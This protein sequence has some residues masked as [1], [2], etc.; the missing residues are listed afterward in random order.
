MTQTLAGSAYTGLV[1]GASGPDPTRGSVNKIESTR[2]YGKVEVD[3]LAVPATGYNSF[4]TK[5]NG[6][7]GAGG[8]AADFVRPSGAGDESSADS[9]ANATRAIPGELTYMFG[10]K[11]PVTNSYKAQDSAEN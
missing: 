2:L 3:V 1:G 4:V 6:P 5:S 10:G 11:L 7:G 9:A 8:T